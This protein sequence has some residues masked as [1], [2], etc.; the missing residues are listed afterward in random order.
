[1][2]EL[3]DGRIIQPFDK[4]GAMKLFLTL[5]TIFCFVVPA[6]A[7][8]C[9]VADVLLTTTPSVPYS[10]R[11]VSDHMMRVTEVE[12]Q[13]VVLIGDSILASWPSPLLQQV[14][15]GRPVLNYSVGNDRVQNTLWRLQDPALHRLSPSM[16]WLMIGTN[17][18]GTAAPCA[19]SKGYDL[20][21]NKIQQLF[22]QAH[23]VLFTVL[24][25]GRDFETYANDRARLN[26]H[27]R[28]RS[29]QLGAD[30]V[31]GDDAITCG[32]IGN[33]SDKSIWLLGP[34]D[35]RS[36]CENYGPD[37]LHL[38]SSGYLVLN[39]LVEESL[40]AEVGN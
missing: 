27:I 14:F 26:E 31:G 19:I 25:R 33:I 16:V 24:P 34:L 11:A 3:T 6:H 38:T 28:V 9:P 10:A 4:F 5:L 37:N 21:L 35:M 39:G 18:L 2:V 1:M 30:F 12:S 7:E 23:L 36:R 29:E 17:N 32:L 22:P 20:I 40:R 8:E 13:D 15:D